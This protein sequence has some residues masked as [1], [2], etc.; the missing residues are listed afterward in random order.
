MEQLYHEHQQTYQPLRQVNGHASFPKEQEEGRLDDYDE[1]EDDGADEE[2][3]INA[4][5]NSQEVDDEEKVR[6]DIFW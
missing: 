2:E 5:K 4:G 6:N 3:E 1:E